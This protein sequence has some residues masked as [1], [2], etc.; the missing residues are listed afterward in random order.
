MK[1]SK[2]RKLIDSI[3]RAIRNSDPDPA[4]M[5]LTPVVNVEHTK[6]VSLSV[7][8]QQ[9]ERAKDAMQEKRKRALSFLATK[10]VL[11]SDETILTGDANESCIEHTYGH[12]SNRHGG[13]LRLDQVLQ[14]H[15]RHHRE[16]VL[17]AGDR[18]E[19][20]RHPVQGREDRRRDDAAE[21]AGS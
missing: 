10:S 6:P 7:L 1:H 20:E 13:R 17:H 3:A 15:G 19:R 8:A 2:L 16:A 18:K 5:T 14:G 12:D 21:L 4:P 11:N 9:S